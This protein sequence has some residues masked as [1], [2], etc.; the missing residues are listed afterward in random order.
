MKKMAGTDFKKKVRLLCP[1]ADW[2]K[3]VDGEMP[4][5]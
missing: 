3:S 2:T 4:G 1:R 5:W